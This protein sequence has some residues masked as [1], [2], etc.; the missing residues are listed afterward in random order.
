MD[1][2]VRSVFN[3]VRE[4]APLLAAA[5]TLEDPARIITVA[6][7][8][9]LIIGGG[10]VYGYTA[11][12]A[13]V[14]HLTKDLAIELADKHI[15]ANS[16]APGLFQSKMARVLIEMNGGEE[17][18]A[19]AS[20]NGRIGRPDDIAG[21]MVFLCSRAGSHINASVIPIDGGKYMAPGAR[22]DTAQESK[23]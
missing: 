13:A 22:R 20:P 14:I 23:L 19:S 8:A 4:T 12:K 3:L 10:G 21:V 16:I 9:G 1:L 6:S 11:S 15:L 2:N 5:G 7:V 18:A 17:G